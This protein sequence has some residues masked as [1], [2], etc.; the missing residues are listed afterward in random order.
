MS[1]LNAL[2]F[3]I[4]QGLTEL[5]PVSS[6][7]HL[8]VI[9]NLFGLV[10]SAFN[11]RMF[12][13]FAHLGTVLAVLVTYWDDLLDMMYELIL[14]F[15][16]SSNPQYSRARYPAARLLLMCACATV[17][18]L[19][20][21]SLNGYIEKLYNS[22]IFMGVCLFMTGVVL[23][24]AGRFVNCRK[25]E[26]SITILDSVLVGVCQAVSSIP[27]LSRT[28]ITMTAGIAVGMRQDF[29][30]K[31]AYLLSIPASLGSNIIHL[32]DASEAGFSFEQLPACLI[33]TAAAFASGL[34]AIKIMK[35]VAARGKFDGFAYYCW[36]AGILFVILTMIF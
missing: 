4:V 7:A 15:T 8:A 17:P 2:F 33:G 27:G 1:I 23:F 28:G 16:A 29:A 9:G 11:F 5:F 21:V 32:I 3:G 14:M 30:L 6:S 31:F 25:A 26:N 22:N 12:T 19:P 18:L 13:I 24:I 34:L 35:S 36:V 10:S 20:V